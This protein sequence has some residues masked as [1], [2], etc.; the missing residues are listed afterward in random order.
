ELPV[1]SAP[2]GASTRHSAVSVSADGGFVAFQFSDQ[3][4]LWDRATGSNTQISTAPD[5]TT[6]GAGA[7][8]DPMITEDASAVYFL[9]VATNLV[10]APNHEL[11]Q[12]Y[13][14]DRATEE[15]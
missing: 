9:S 7:S 11:F 4:Y 13:R 6:P 10:A 3:V 2:L 14:Y 15:I 8:Q 12:L 1:P 5:G